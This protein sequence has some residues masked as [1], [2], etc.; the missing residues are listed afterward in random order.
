MKNNDLT[1]KSTRSPQMVQPS[2]WQTVAAI[3]QGYVS[4][5]L[6]P[7]AKLSSTILGFYL[8]TSVG[9]NRENAGNETSVVWFQVTEMQGMATPVTDVQ[10]KQSHYRER[11]DTLFSIK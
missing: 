8:Q 2:F 11:N 4:I 3:L 7:R 10:I 9:W 5:S 1:F 6:R